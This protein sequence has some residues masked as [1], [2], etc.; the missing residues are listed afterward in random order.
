MGAA[1]FRMAREREAAR[2]AAQAAEQAAQAE[3]AK[4]SPAKPETQQVGLQ[5]VGTK[6]KAKPVTTASQ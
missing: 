6:P 5:S 3:A 1:S 4:E 2:Q